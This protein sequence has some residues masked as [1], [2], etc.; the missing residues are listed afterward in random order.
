MNEAPVP[1]ISPVPLNF[2]KYVAIDENQCQGDEESPESRLWKHVLLQL[3]Y[4]IRKSI[5]DIRNLS[6]LIHSSEDDPKVPIIEKEKAFDEF[7][8]LWMKFKD[9]KE[10]TET[11]HFVIVCDL[12]GH[13]VQQVRA[14]VQKKCDKVYCM[15]APSVAE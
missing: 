14:S 10:S 15:T 6:L 8:K 7:K 11:E 12:A 1:M 2:G 3:F 5:D 4:D 13:D 9:I